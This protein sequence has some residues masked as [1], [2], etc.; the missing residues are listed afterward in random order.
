MSE[1]AVL[2]L[3]FGV[4]VMML[5]SELFIPSH[6]ILTVV[7]VGFLIAGVVAT[8]QTYGEKAGAIAIICCLVALPI[9]T[10]AA[11]RIWPKTWVGRRIAPPN[12]VATT[13]DTSV[14]VVELSRYIGQTGR[15]TTPLRPVGICDFDGRR[16]P[17]IAEFGMVEAGVMVEG[18][19]MTGGN[20]SV[21]EKKA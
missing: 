6:G 4:G 7:G 20:L 8:F 18:L 10:V 17:C 11:V 9:F 1:L 12:P 3:L 14:P 15:S 13:R 2:L 19:R 21:Q 16:I 5:V